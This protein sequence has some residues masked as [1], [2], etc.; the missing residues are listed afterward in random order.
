MA[1]AEGGSIGCGRR[2]GLRFLAL[3][4]RGISLISLQE[5]DR[6]SA[7]HALSRGLGNCGDETDQI[8]IGDKVKR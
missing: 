6:P 3:P 7:G 4:Q 8:Q 2:V 1:A 5:R